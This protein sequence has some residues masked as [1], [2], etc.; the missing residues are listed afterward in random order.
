MN[1]VSI[2]KTLGVCSELLY[3][4]KEVTE[5]FDAGKAIRKA[6]DLGYGDHI[7]IANDFF[8]VA[9]R[10][11]DYLVMVGLAKLC[12]RDDGSVERLYRRCRSNEGD[13]NLSDDSLGEL[14]EI[15]GD[16][17]SFKQE[18]EAIFLNIKT[19]RDKYYAHNDK[20]YFQN[21]KGL[22]DDAPLSYDDIENVLKSLRKFCMGIYS[23]LA[24]EEWKPVLHQDCLEHPRNCNDLYQLLD[25]CNMDRLDFL[26]QNPDEYSEDR[27]SYQYLID[28]LEQ[29]F[30]CYLESSETSTDKAFFDA[31]LRDLKAALYGISFDECYVFSFEVRTE[32]ELTYVRFN[33][34]ADYVEVYSGGS[35][36]DPHIGSD[37]YSNPKYIF[38]ESDPD[39]L[40]GLIDAT[41]G[42]I[43]NGAKLVIE[44]PETY[45]DKTEE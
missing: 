19:R 36:Y 11:L 45:I 3:Q 15:L 22:V 39:E 24:R 20:K 26:N 28:S 40:V 27:E 38:G 8:V 4:I 18:H 35:V 10:A 2:Q 44:L 43:Q 7:H 32:Y 30:H 42:L 5:Y 41:F 23:L 31:V 1:G 6:P 16:F 17:E 12:S 13:F 37:S 21:R 34:E 33:I 25:I 14:Q 9:G 29:L